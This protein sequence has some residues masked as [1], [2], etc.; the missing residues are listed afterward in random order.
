MLENQ[1]KINIAEVYSA[2]NGI[3]SLY[4]VNSFSELSKEILGAFSEDY[5]SIGYESL[6]CEIGYECLVKD[7]D[8]EKWTSFYNQ[9]DISHKVHV[10][11]GLGWAFSKRKLV[12]SDYFDLFN[13]GEKWL[14]LDGCG[15]FD[16]LFRSRKTITNQIYPDLIPDEFLFA[17]YQG[18]GRQQLYSKEGD[19]LKIK[20]CIFSFPLRFQGDMWRGVGIASGY[21]GGL[22]DKDLSLYRFEGDKPF[23]FGFSIGK[24]SRLNAECFRKNDLVECKFLNLN[25]LKNVQ[26]EINDFLRTNILKGD[27]K[28]EFSLNLNHAE[29]ELMHSVN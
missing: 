21:V 14:I 20:E 6:S 2:F 4:S 27:S 12:F 23:V 9:V 26:K 11:V 22:M 18:V 10:L 24:V 29:S 1:L 13:D 3:S 8:L 16:A 7:Q 17:Y 25:I 28:N 15:Y 5:V 19:F